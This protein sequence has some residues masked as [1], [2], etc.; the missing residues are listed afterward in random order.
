M[1][2]FFQ[3]VD[4]DEV[5][6]VNSFPFRL[7][8][9]LTFSGS[10]DFVVTLEATEDKGALFLVED[11]YDISTWRGEFSP[12]YLV[13]ITRKTGKEKTYSQF[14]GTIGTALKRNG[15]QPFGAQQQFFVDILCYD[16][17]QLLKAKRDYYQH[18]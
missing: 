14:M 2:Q 9:S 5:R 4:F 8:T 1:Q 13:E 10:Q 6:G 7:Q 17:L 3:G 11:K 16:D 15:T 12:A 18:Q